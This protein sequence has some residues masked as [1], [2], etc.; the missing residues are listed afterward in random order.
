MYVQGSD[1]IAG[2]PVM[3]NSGIFACANGGWIHAENWWLR[4]IGEEIQQTKYDPFLVVRCSGDSY[5]GV[6]NS[7]P[8]QIVV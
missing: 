1:I 6:V 5:T 7:D 4:S 8:P 2:A 3:P